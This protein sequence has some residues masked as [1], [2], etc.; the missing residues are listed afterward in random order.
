[1]WYVYID[2]IHLIIIHINA[3]NKLSVVLLSILFFDY[4]CFFIEYRQ[5]VSQAF[6]DNAIQII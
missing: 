3:L 1:M 5:D 2:L 4:V 6:R